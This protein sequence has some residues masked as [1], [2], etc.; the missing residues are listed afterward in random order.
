TSSAA[1]AHMIVLETGLVIMELVKHFVAHSV[2]GRVAEAHAAGHV[3]EALHLAGS[4]GSLSLTNA[5]V[6][7]VD[8]VGGGEAGAGAAGDG[9]G[10]AGDAAA[11]VLVP[12]GMRF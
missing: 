3:G 7:I 9:A 4:R 10:A 1:Y 8:D 11:V 12:H 2:A 5:A 6:L